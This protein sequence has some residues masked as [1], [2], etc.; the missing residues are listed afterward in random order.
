[1][2]HALSIRFVIYCVTFKQIKM[3]RWWWMHNGFAPFARVCMRACVRVCV[4]K[5]CYLLTRH[6]VEYLTHFHRTYIT[7][8]CTEMNASQFRVKGQRS[9]SRWNTVCW[10]QHF[11]G[12]KTISR[13]FTKL[14][15]MMYYGTEMNALNFG[16]RSQWNS[17]MMEPS[18]YMRRHTVLN[19]SCRV[20]LSTCSLQ[21]LSFIV[22]IITLCFLIYMAKEN[23]FITQNGTEH[24]VTHL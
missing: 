1:M 13:T 12:L 17:I 6:L 2:Y 15:P 10:K 3:M 7:M 23:S 8:H 21:M 20:R 19:V 18:L 14:T 4:P 5:H 24:W 11:L 16:S 9:R 22:R